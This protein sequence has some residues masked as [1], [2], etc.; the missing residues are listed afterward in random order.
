MF[1][2]TARVRMSGFN[3]RKDL[4][5]HITPEGP[6][7][8]IKTPGVAIFRSNSCTIPLANCIEDTGSKTPIRAWRATRR[9]RWMQRVRSLSLSQRLGMSPL[10]SVNRSM[11]VMTCRQRLRGVT[12][13]TCGYYFGNQLPYLFGAML[14]MSCLLNLERAAQPNRHNNGVS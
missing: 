2:A 5:N 8:G 13:T 12:Q 4:H 3:R 7:A 11:N 10:G 6:G 1:Q 14:A 9:H